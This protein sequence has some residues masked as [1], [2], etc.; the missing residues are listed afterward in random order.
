MQPR[1]VTAFCPYSLESWRSVAFMHNRVR[2]AVL[3]LNNPIHV[4][5][6]ATTRLRN[7]VESTVCVSCLCPY[8]CRAILWLSNRERMRSTWESVE[9]RFLLSL[10]EA[11]PLWQGAVTYG[12]KGGLNHSKGCSGRGW[13]GTA[14]RTGGAPPGPPKWG[15]GPTTTVT[16]PE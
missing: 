16:L 11:S 1:L 2:E 14:A 3:S 15:A 8:K 7:N 10:A 4:S 12:K 6:C 5:Q 9:Y 13:H